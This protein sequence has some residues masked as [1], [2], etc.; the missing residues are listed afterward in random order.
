MFITVCPVADCSQAFRLIE[1]IDAEHLFTDKG[2]DRDAFVK[3]LQQTGVNPV[4]PPRKSRKR[5][6]TY[7]KYLSR[8][9][10]FIENVFLELKR[11][12][13]VATRYAKNTSTFL[14][15]VHIR[16]IAIWAKIK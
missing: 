11:W 2:Y 16:C 9:R 3:S 8:L 6:R 10:H 13:G 14:A 4:T 5:L 1:G 15:A 7:D 12:R